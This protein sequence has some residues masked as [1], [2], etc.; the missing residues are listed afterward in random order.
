[1]VRPRAK[2]YASLYTPRPTR[3]LAMIE[4]VLFIAIVIILLFYM[5]IP[6]KIRLKLL[7]NRAESYCCRTAEHLQ[8]AYDLKNTTEATWDNIA[9]QTPLFAQQEADRARQLNCIWDHIRHV[10][11]VQTR[12]ARCKKTLDEMLLH[13]PALDFSD[14]KNKLM[15]D[16]VARDVD[17]Q[18]WS[19]S[20]LQECNNGI[21]Q[22]ATESCDV[23]KTNY[24]PGPAGCGGTT[25]Q[26]W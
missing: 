22:P 16:L 2:K 15:L 14:P 4:C 12:N 5:D 20:T 25:T 6:N 7:A 9:Q 21:M 18:G 8:H 26:W 17:V 13:Y 11:E 1:M 19:V 3:H 23:G 10:E 24:K